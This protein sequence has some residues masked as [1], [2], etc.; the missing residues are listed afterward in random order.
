MHGN[1]AVCRN[2]AIPSILIEL[3]FITIP[4]SEELIQTE[5]FQKNVAEA[6]AKGI[7]EWCQL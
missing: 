3:D 4:E 7:K 1:L 6:I 5:K 2:P